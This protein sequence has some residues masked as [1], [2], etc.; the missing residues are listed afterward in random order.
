MKFLLP[1]LL[2]FTIPT[3]ADESVEDEQQER[4]SGGGACGG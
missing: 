4:P 2:L 1:F 3:F